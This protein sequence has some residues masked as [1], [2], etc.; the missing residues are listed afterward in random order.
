MIRE[1]DAD[2]VL[3]SVH[4]LIH[5]VCTKVPDRAEYR[6]KISQVSALLHCLKGCRI[7]MPMFIMP[8]VLLGSIICQTCNHSTAESSLTHA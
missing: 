2:S 5:H 3:E 1:I 7:I 6:T 4:T 8:F